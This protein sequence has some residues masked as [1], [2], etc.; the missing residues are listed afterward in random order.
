MR[1]LAL[2]FAVSPR[3][4]ADR[5]HRFLADHG[6]ARVRVQV[7]HPDDVLAEHYDVLVIDDICSFLTPTLV[8]DVTAR[9]RRVVG[10][11]ER[12]R[13]EGKDRLAECGIE[14]TV[15][16]SADPDDFL[17]A[18]AIAG[19]GV[20]AVD[21]PPV[22]D[23]PE[24]GDRGRVYAVGG[25]AGGCGITEV[26]LGLAARLGRHRRVVLVDADPSR[27]SLAPRLGLP[28]HPNLRS[29]VDELEHR[30]TIPEPSTRA[31]IAVLAG[32]GGG[33]ALQGVRPGR[34]LDVVHR[35]ASDRC[36]V[37]VD[38]GADPGD[39]VGRS[40]IAATL[41]ENADAVV[42]VGAATPV[43]V[44]R[45]LDWLGATV[46][47]R[48]RSPVMLAFNR[49]PTSPYRRAQLA[50]EILRSYVPCGLVFLPSDSAV[51]EA[52]WRGEPVGRG[53]F[54]TALAR[55]ASRLEPVASA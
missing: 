3:E 7:L 40:G 18:V 49:A 39:A 46:P 34:V 2:A 12:S 38:L 11:Y 9:G 45:M 6:G 23:G 27:P 17:D 44:V 20:V 21:D 25:P 37:V 53:R 22:T 52:A 42:G 8:A 54:T 43:G 47:I 10:V 28:L 13:P 4:W 55:L 5:F 24:N 41:I 36:D 48:P 29:A 30:G 32:G 1:D 51:T 50:E 26:A 16:A 33:E 15:E 35:L 31:G 19:E 14:V